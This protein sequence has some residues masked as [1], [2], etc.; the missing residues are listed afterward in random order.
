MLFPF[1]FVHYRMRA[2]PNILKLRKGFQAGLIKK[3][4]WIIMP[5]LHIGQLINLKKCIFVFFYKFDPVFR[6]GRI[7]RA[8]HYI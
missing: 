6:F 3:T 8:N 7:G 1:F 4:V 2:I 5:V